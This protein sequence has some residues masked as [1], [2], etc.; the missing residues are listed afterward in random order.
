[1]MR[2]I[3]PLSLPRKKIADICRIPDGQIFKLI[4]IYKGWQRIFI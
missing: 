4:V 2:D 1:M 3:I